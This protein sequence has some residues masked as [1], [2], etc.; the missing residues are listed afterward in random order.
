MFP[1]LYDIYETIPD[2]EIERYQEG[3]FN[4]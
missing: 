4:D 1:M 2:V 3:H